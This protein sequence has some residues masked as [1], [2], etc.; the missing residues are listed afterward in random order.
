MLVRVLVWPVRILHTSSLATY[1]V[2]LIFLCTSHVLYSINCNLYLE[3][4]WLVIQW[5]HLGKRIHIRYV[6]VGIH[7]LT[8]FEHGENLGKTI[9]V[10]KWAERREI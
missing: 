3:R 1:I 10:D 2:V 9:I 4:I 8:K 6:V 5:V 7:G